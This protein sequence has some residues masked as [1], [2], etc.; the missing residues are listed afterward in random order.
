VDVL[1]FCLLNVEIFRLN[2]ATIFLWALYCFGCVDD[3]LT[4]VVGVE[5]VCGAAGCV[6]MVFSGLDKF[7]ES[8][9]KF[10]CLAYILH[11]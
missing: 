10:A 6:L 3:I 4:L 5:D 9:Y 8:R 1:V 11:A 2:S 7:F